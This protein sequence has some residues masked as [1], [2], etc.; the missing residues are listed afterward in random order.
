LYLRPLPHGQGS[1]RPA[2]AIGAGFNLEPPL[3]PLR[4][5]TDNSCMRLAF[6][7]LCS[8]LA[9]SVVSDSG[10]ASGARTLSWTLALRFR[11]GERIVERSYA[12]DRVDWKLPKHRLEPFIKGGVII[13]EEQ[14]V[15][16]TI[17]AKVMAV[18]RSVASL[19]GVGTVVSVDV[20]RHHTQSSRSTFSTAV[21]A[22]NVPVPSVRL[23]LED[24]AM[25]ALPVHPVAAGQRWSTRLAVNTTLGSGSAVFVHTLVGERNGLLEIAVQGKGEITGAEYHLPKLLPGSIALTGTAWFDPSSRLV[26]RES[27]AIHNALIKPM[28]GEQNG[29]DERVSVD[30]TTR[31]SG[32]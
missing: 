26:V 21:A 32:P 22:N 15:T 20:P 13:N 4:L 30:T 29:F 17:D 19:H 11:V 1:L 23:Q 12:D 9:A 7:L 3:F 18:I 5:R 27:Y 10:P 6:V 2:V 24:A 8:C 28:E 16:T 14:H 25:A 31:G